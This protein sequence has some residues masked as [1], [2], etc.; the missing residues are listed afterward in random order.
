MV[1]TGNDLYMSSFVYEAGAR[2]RGNVLKYKRKGSDVVGHGD[3]ALFDSTGAVVEDT[4]DLWFP[5]ALS[6]TNPPENPIP[7][8]GL[9]RKLYNQIN[10]GLSVESNA[11][12]EDVLTAVKAQRNI[13]YPDKTNF[14]TI[15]D[16]AVNK[17]L[18]IPREGEDKGNYGDGNGE[19]AMDELYRFLTKKIYGYGYNWPLGDI[20]HSN[21]V[22]AHYP[23]SSEQDAD[24]KSYLFVGANDGMLHCFNASSDSA[25]LQAGKEIWAIVYP[26]FRIRLHELETYFDSEEHW[27]ADGYIAIY[28]DREEASKTDED[29]NTVKYIVKKPKYLIAGE[30]RGGDQYHIIDISSVDAP[31]Y[32]GAVGKSSDDFVWGQS[33]SKPQLCQVKNSSNV[34]TKG[35]LVGGGYDTS[36]DNAYLAE[37]ED[38]DVK[39]GRFVA[40][41]DFTGTSIHIF[42]DVSVSGQSEAL[43]ACIVDA[44]IVDHDHV[45]GEDRIFS[46]IYA[47]DLKG[48][49]YRWE[50][51]NEKGTWGSKHKLFL[52][53]TTDS[54]GLDDHPPF[55]VTIDN[56]ERDL[57]QKVFYA[58]VAGVACSEDRVFFCTGDREHPLMEYETFS[59][60]VY[61]VPDN[62]AKTYTRKDLVKFTLDD[63]KI[64]EKDMEGNDLPEDGSP[65]KGII[66][67]VYG[68]I[69]KTEAENKGSCESSCDESSCK[70]V[71]PE[72]D[73]SCTAECIAN[74]KK[75]CGRGWYF[76]FCRDGEK[77]ISSPLVLKD[78]LVFGTYTPPAITTTSDP[79]NAG[80]TCVPGK[81][82]IYVVSS[83]EDA[84]AVKSYKLKNNPMPQPSLVFDA[85]S[86][87][88]LISTGD[89]TIIDPKLPVVVP[90]YWKHSGSNL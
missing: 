85:K 13:L 78:V 15:A 79:C 58:P 30:R 76:D 67:E 87:K 49:V 1:Y 89:G 86:G 41:Y 36:Q 29:G 75:Q 70:D 28:Y 77:V 8:D 6:V 57:Y 43:E 59:D 48:N 23:E 11:E 31:L 22:V 74:C 52:N 45:G 20:V 32:V 18:L 21:I 19:N 82:R 60:S 17:T 69:L 3:A 9:A 26:D 24:V 2:G 64:A 40:L 16:L 12:P 80:G 66:Q 25:E 56:K 50:D 37:E 7:L 44:R 38:G 88:V 39:K 83:C 10:T 51:E 61:C 84:F 5:G 4:K 65:P 14:K 68:N 46:R 72:S 42:D 73:P 27:F 33:W 55:K 81:G 54:S 34:L 71:C 53:N 63:Q 90:D 35:F 47:G 62:T